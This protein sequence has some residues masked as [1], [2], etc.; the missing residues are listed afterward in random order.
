[1]G[2]GPPRSDP[3]PGRRFSGVGHGRAGSASRGRVCASDRRRCPDRR[4]RVSTDVR[5]TLSQ[6][7]QLLRRGDAA[8]A[9]SLLETLAQRDPAAAAHADVQLLTAQASFQMRDAAAAESH[10]RAALASR[11]DSAP[12]N[13]LLGMVLADLN[14]LDE[15]AHHLARSLALRPANLRTLTNLGVVHRR[16]GATADADRAFRQA[17]AL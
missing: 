2:R 15:S 12:A 1:M 11:P 4:S 9:R 14:R 3:S 17:I 13:A 16:R 10:A 5:G 6:A 8:A 7:D